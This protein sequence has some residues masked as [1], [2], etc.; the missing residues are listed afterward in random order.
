VPRLLLLPALAACG[1]LAACGG[2]GSSHTR[3]V[4]IEPITVQGHTVT[5][6]V[7]PPGAIKTH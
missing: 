7:I 1:F 5:R 3:T 4:T 2:S 6:V